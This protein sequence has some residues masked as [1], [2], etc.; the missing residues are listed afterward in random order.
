MRHSKHH[1]S[2][3]DRLRMPEVPLSE[4]RAPTQG[5]P[6]LSPTDQESSD[7]EQ[8]AS[9]NAGYMLGRRTARGCSSAAYHSED[10]VAELSHSLDT[11]FKP[12]SVAVVGASVTPGTVGS[13]LMRN[14]LEN[15]FGG[16]V[17]PVNPKRNAV[18][19]VH[20]YPNLAAVPKPV[21]L[22]VVSTPAATVPGVVKE[23]VD[24]GIP[25][26]ILISA[27]FSELGAEGRVLEDQIRRIAKGRMRVIGPNCLGVIRPSAGSTPVL[28]PPW[29]GPATWP[30]SARAAPCVRPSSTGPASPGSVS[31]V[32]S[33][34]G[35]WST[36]ISP[37]SSTTSPTTCIPA[38]SSSTW[39]RSA[40]CA[41]S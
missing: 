7:D 6:A 31:A 20:C 2:W 11:I 10:L 4:P 38:A 16:V 9:V 21:D 41:S 5:R 15:P 23:C 29:L 27:G 33:A 19:G 17:Y 25:A 37:T 22:A 28:R 40:M 39:S 35:P 13:I 36:S 14:L 24:N 12:R 26:A 18:H 3:I 30:C 1:G 8:S 34:W 32:S